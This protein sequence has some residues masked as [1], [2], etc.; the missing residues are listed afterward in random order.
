MSPWHRF[1]SFVILLCF[2][3]QHVR[4]PLASLE[5]HKTR[6]IDG[7]RYTLNTLQARAGEEPPS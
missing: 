3:I 7:R 5:L 4:S 6:T 2:R 1:W